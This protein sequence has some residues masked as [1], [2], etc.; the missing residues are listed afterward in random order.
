MTVRKHRRARW[1]IGTWMRLISGDRLGRLIDRKDLSYRE[2]AEEVGCSK[3]KIGHL[4]K[5]IRPTCT[6]ELAERI[7]RR[8]DIDLDVLFV[9]SVPIDD[10]R[11]VQQRK[12]AA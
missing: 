12:V 11:S 2:F 1:P 3:S 5:G 10:G 4:V 8:L 7:A 6:P 9:P